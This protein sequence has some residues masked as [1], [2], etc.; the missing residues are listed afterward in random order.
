MKDSRISG[1][2]SDSIIFAIGNMGTKL[3]MFIM[4]P[5]YTFFLTTSEYGIVDLSVTTVTLLTP[6]VTLSV[7]DAVFRFS[8]DKK[9]TQSVFS[10]GFLVS[11]IGSILTILIGVIL[12]FLTKKTLYVLVSFMIIGNVFLSFLQNFSRGIGQKK[13]FVVL[14]LI[15]AIIGSVSTIVLLFN[16]QTVSSVIWGNIIGLT[17]ANL[18]GIVIQKRQNTFSR[19]L[20]NRAS[21]FELLQYSIPLLPNAV[22]WWITTDIARFIILIFVGADGNGIYA[23][24][25]KIPALL[26]IFFG[27]FNQAWQITAV[28]EIDSPDKSQFYSKVFNS[29]ILVSFVGI[30]GILI[31]IKPIMSVIVHYS[32]FESW[33]LVPVLLV[34]VVFSNLSAFVGT[35]YVASK[36]T[37]AIMFTTF[38]GMG[39]N[40]VSTLILIPFIG[41][42][43]AGI[44]SVIGFFVILL[45]RIYTTRNIVKIRIS[46]FALGFNLILI[47]IQTYALMANIRFGLVINLFIL[48]I[49]IINNIISIKKIGSK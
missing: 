31:V 46:Y 4:V 11:V 15:S 42:Q 29:L 18:I 8:L 5:V 33:K 43:G 48:M 2:L 49:L 32:F 23:V 41:I 21:I 30:S 17:V 26:T 45:V 40:T 20:I 44:G 36:K 25:S 10:N 9:N 7:F 12:L 37:T 24:A 19:R 22:A 14:G 27:V 34:S 1:L 3:I 47:G 39:I 13:T 38:L 28:K 35:V 6:I 16:S